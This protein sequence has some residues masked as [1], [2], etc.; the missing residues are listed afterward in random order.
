MQD[1]WSFSTFS[2]LILDEL[3]DTFEPNIIEGEIENMPIKENKT[4]RSCEENP[5]A[6]NHDIHEEINE[7]P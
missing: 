6:S 4:P 5:P 1:P 7:N 3:G 2:D